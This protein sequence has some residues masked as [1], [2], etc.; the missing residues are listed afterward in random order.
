MEL[1][2]EKK[3]ANN[4]KEYFNYYLVNGSLKVLIKPTFNNQNSLLKALYLIEKNEV[5][6]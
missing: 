3:I 2:R 4:G 6:K 1:V 5:N